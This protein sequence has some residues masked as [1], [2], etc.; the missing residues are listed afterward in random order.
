M[1]TVSAEIGVLACQRRAV[2]LGAGRRVD[3]VGWLEHVDGTR[4][5]VVVDPCQHPV[6]WLVLNPGDEAVLQAEGGPL[7]AP[8]DPELEAALA[9]VQRRGQAVLQR[10]I[11]FREQVAVARLAGASAIPDDLVD[12]ATSVLVGGEEIAAQF[13]QTLKLAGTITG[14]LKALRREA[15][16]FAAPTE[17]AP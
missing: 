6:E 14:E 1:S 7:A 5:A 3:L 11:T 12:L 4:R 15:E 2:A 13:S 16:V 8:S 10:C 9:T 17:E